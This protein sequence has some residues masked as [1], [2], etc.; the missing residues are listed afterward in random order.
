VIKRLFNGILDFIIP[1]L[2]VSC[3]SPVD[4]KN[5]FICLKCRAML[6]RFDTYPP[7]RNEYISLG[8]INDSLSMYR[9]V[10]DS[11]VQHLLHSLKYEKM[12]SIGLMLG[13]EIAEIIPPSVKFDYAVPV[14]LHRAK[15]RERTYNQSEFICRG[16]AEIPGITVIPKLL[17]RNRFTKS[18]TK[19]DKHQ[20]IDNVKNAFEINPK[21]KGT[22]TGKNIVLADDVIT[23]GATILECSRVLKEAGAGYVLVCSAAY[24]ALD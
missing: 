7:W 1:P 19:M 8:Y 24:D 15:E 21:H 20:R 17:E 22:V 2:C 3:G 11:P 6:I 10:K 16:I 9:F 13:K 4:E 12:K 23:T 14:P 5:G 18:Q